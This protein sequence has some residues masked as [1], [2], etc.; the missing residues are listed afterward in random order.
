MARPIRIEYPGAVYHITARGNGRKNIFKGEEDRDIFL[1][2]VSS[3]VKRYN[4]LCHAYCLMDNHYHLV[5]ETPD[6]N[7]SK[8]MQQL[9]G[10][11][12]QAFNRRHDRCGHIFQGRYKA[13]VVDKESYLAELCRYVVLNP[14]RAK[15]ASA[16]ED[17]QWSSYSIT[18]GLKEAPHFLSVDWVLG[19]FGRD[20]REAE[21]GCR[22]FV[23]A[24]IGIDCPWEK[25]KGQ[26]LLGDDEFVGKLKEALSSKKTIKEI[27][28]AQRH[29]HRPLL[30]ELFK[31]NEKVD[32]QR[33]NRVILDAHILHGY[34]LKEIADTLGIHY[35]TA[36]KVVN[37]K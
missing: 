24:G 21:R 10:I 30:H 29:A 5:I 13:I 37:R 22:D 27:P 33:R 35:T 36:S 14:V 15:I 17:W 12:T 4:W 31:G 8:G 19:L 9:N 26:V 6:G 23:L 34:S 25:L 1:A 2:V 18:V 32:K 20:K 7:L 28:K 16:P 11:Y 3:V